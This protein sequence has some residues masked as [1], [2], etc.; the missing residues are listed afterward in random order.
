MYDVE[1]VRFTMEAL[2]AM[3]GLTTWTNEVIDTPGGLGHGLYID[4]VMN[5][6]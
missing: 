6:E 4:T 5:D 1:D 3:E 2:S